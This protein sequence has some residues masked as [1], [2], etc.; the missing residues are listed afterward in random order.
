MV[1]LHVCLIVNV[2][3]CKR[4]Y[5]CLDVCVCVCVCRCVCT[6]ICV[7]VCGDVR[8]VANRAGPSVRI[9]AG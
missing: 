8:F 1:G 3:V 9:I 7:C 4:V 6:H 2:Q 5:A